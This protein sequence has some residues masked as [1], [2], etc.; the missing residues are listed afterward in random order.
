MRLSEATVL[1]GGNSQIDTLDVQE[2]DPHEDLQALCTLAEQAQRFSPIVGLEQLDKK[3]WAGRSLHYPES[4]LLDIT[5]IAPLFGG[6]PQ[7]LQEVAN[8]LSAQRLFGCLAIANSVGAAWA[9]ANYGLRQERPHQVLKTKTQTTAPEL[10]PPCRGCIASNASA[11]EPTDE[12]SE[13]L[14]LTS[15]PLTAL[16]LD[17]D[18][19]SKLQRLG[20]RNIDQ[21]QQL[22]RDGMASRLGEH[23]LSRWDQITGTQDEPIVTLH[24]L[25]DWSLEQELEYPTQNRETIIELVRRLSQDLSGRLRRRGEGA[26]R[27]VCRLDLVKAT[28]LVTQL[29]LFRPSNDA[30]H[31]QML[32]TGQLE[33]QLR[34]LGKAPMW[35]LVLQATLTAPMVWRQSDLF[36]NGESNDR[37]EIG[38]LVDNLSAR[39]GRK[40]VL[41]AK[42][43]RDAQPEL[44][45]SF[46]PMTGR[47]ADGTGP[48]TTKKLSSRLARKR[49]E[50]SRDDPMRRPTQLLSPPLELQTAGAWKRSSASETKTD[51][52]TPDHANFPASPTASAPA[53]F[54]FKN[55]WFQVIEARGPERLESGWWKGPSCRR[56]YYRVITSNGSWWW[57][58]RD[59]ITTQW[60]L[61][62]LF[63]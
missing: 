52:N 28:P 50:P 14:S 23:L 61:H 59:L 15:L 10:I 13:D 21:L 45:S 57:I 35:R 17:Q 37:H 26:L 11:A 49:A 36:D 27:I 1:I 51:D 25:P 29:G 54:Q 18:T 63:D 5:G 47:R 8:W 7:I 53:K 4:L 20:V 41:S 3:R 55:Q 2:H 9:I 22:P 44:A 24:S 16:R 40:N 58:Y 6:E 42:I 56:D 43:R 48:D 62:G 32:L 46:H 12:T 60:F 39:L 33:Q 19:I 30:A 34:Q 31:L 38:R